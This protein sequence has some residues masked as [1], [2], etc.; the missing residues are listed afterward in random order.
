MCHYPTEKQRAEIR[1]L[2]RDNSWWWRL[3]RIFGMLGPT[4]VLFAGLLS[5][6]NVYHNTQA[7]NF[8]RL[9]NDLGNPGERQ[10]LA[11]VSQ[12]MTYQ[13]P[14]SLIARIARSTFGGLDVKQRTK[15]ITDTV[16]DSAR[17]ETGQTVKQQIFRLLKVKGS[18]ALSS[19]K[20]LRFDLI[21][22][23]G[24]IYLT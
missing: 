9:L 2:K 21:R 15:I 13:P 22:H 10:R 12:L 6:L 14:N 1:K 17:L 3:A 5:V 8:R 7:D 20:R 24:I 16:V 19:L 23:L 18:L 11:T 4:L